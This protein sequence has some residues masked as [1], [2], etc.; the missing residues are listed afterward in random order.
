MVLDKLVLVCKF[1]RDHFE[2]SPPCPPSVFL[3]SIKN[4][5]QSLTFVDELR[6]HEE[7]TRTLFADI[8]GPVPNLLDL[9]I[10]E[11]VATIPLKNNLCF[12]QRRKYTIPKHWS[13]VMDDI[14][15]LHLSQGFIRPSNSLFS[16]PSFLVPKSDPKALPRWVCDYRHINGN[17]VS[18]NY[19]MPKNFGDSL[20]LRSRQIFL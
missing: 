20:R 19:P 3:A 8:F 1:R 4:R 7:S 9:P 15:N 2:N 6:K 10:T 12:P 18:D 17:T 14:I 5:I 16:S 11:T 13:K